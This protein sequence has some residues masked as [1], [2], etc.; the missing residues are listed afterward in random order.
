MPMAHLFLLLTLSLLTPSAPKG[1]TPNQ[2][3]QG[4]KVLSPDGSLAM[5]V[6]VGAEL[7]Y[8]VELEGTPLVLPSPLSLTLRGGPVLGPDARLSSS[9][10]ETVDEILHTVIPEKDA[11]IRDH[12]NG[13]SLDFEGGWGLDIRAYDDGVAYRFRIDRPGEL[14]VAD[15]GVEVAFPADPK[16]W[17]PTEE[18]FLTHS[19]RLYEELLLSAIP[20]E[21]MASLPVLVALPQGPKVLITESDLQDYPG[22]YLRGESGGSLSGLFPTYPA[23]EEQVRDRTVRVTAREDYLAR[24]LGPRTFPWRVF[25][26]AEE[27]RELVEST[28]IYRLAPPLRIADPGWIRPGK[29]AWDWWNASTLHGVD[30]ESGLNTETYLY[31]I[32]FAADHGIEYI[33][34][35]EGWSNPADLHELNPD[36]DLDALLAR[37]GERGVGLIL[38]VV[39][40]T[41]DDE[42]EEALDRFAAMGVAGVKVDF[43]QRDDQPMVNYYWRVAEAAARRRLVVDFPWSL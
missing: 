27:D 42:L 15:E 11:E 23:A 4:H 33:I 24:T 8:S 26:V 20:P 7:T 39:W 16:L 1:A 36:M 6:A 5:R 21:K 37:A 3:A 13:L 9:R 43:M 35:D 31:F 10:S 41:L 40:K 18:S 12:F 25:L 29:V 28:L 32:D 14:V 38:W 17:F 34:L 30:F 2:E 19:E 22:L